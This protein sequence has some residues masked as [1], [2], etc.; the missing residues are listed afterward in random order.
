MDPERPCVLRVRADGRV[1]RTAR[2]DRTPPNAL[3]DGFPIHADKAGQT[4]GR[5]ATESGGENYNCFFTSDF[6][7]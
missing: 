3:Q 4:G 1:K 6:D 7:M 5:A 2:A